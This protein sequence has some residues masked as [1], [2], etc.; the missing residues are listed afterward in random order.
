MSEMSCFHHSEKRGTF[1]VPNR[2]L[3]DTGTDVFNTHKVG[4]APKK[5]G[6][7]VIPTLTPTRNRTRATPVIDSHSGDYNRDVTPF[8]LVRG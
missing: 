3:R 6:T 8:S 2:I 1:S 4:T 5:P 7:N